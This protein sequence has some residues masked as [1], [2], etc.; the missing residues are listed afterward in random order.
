MLAA[1]GVGWIIGFVDFIAKRR[2]RMVAKVIS[3]R[4]KVP[5]CNCAI[6]F[7]LRCRL[8]IFETQFPVIRTDNTASFRQHR[9]VV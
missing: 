8:G 9:P 5:N 1:A 7:L 6:R 2:G 3:S 4:F